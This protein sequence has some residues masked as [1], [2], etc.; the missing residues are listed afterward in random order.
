MDFSNYKFRPSCLGKLMVDPRSKKESLSETT[1][2]YLKEIYI[3]EMFGRKREITSKYMEKGTM[4]EE[5]S[6]SLASSVLDVM[7]LKNEETL[8]NDYIKGTP[9]LVFDSQVWDIKSSWDIWTFANADGENKDYYWQL[10]GY[11]W[12]MGLSKAKLVYCLVN[13]PAH[14]IEDEVRVQTYRRGMLGQEETPEF[15]KMEADIEYLMTFDDIDEKLRVKVF[16]YE[17][18]EEQIEKL[19]ERIEAARKYLSEMTL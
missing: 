10:R 12:L 8:E 2:S 6:I 5:D 19:K 15:Y 7:L 16:D 13:S 14:L 4:V 3:E 1:K 18:E 11:T 17:F 9:D